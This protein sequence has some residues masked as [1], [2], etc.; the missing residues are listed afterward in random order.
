MLTLSEIQQLLRSCCVQGFGRLNCARSRLRTLG[1]IL[2]GNLHCISGKV[3]AQ[4]RES[5]MVLP[6]RSDYEERPKKNKE[7]EWMVGNQLH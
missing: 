5:K 2:A 1:K 4:W 3:K 6:E 7:N